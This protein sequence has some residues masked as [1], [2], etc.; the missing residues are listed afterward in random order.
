MLPLVWWHKKFYLLKPYQTEINECQKRYKLL[1]KWFRVVLTFIFIFK[2]ISAPNDARVH[3]DSTKNTEDAYN[4]TKKLR[5][6]FE[7]SYEKSSIFSF[8]CYWLDTSFKIFT[9][10]VE[11]SSIYKYHLKIV[12][13]NANFNSELFLIAITQ[14]QSVLNWKFCPFSEIRNS[15]RLKRF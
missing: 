13:S 1:L 12:V 6:I 15:C 5:K 11:T 9:F 14:I 7:I 8:K 2:G 10:M 3:F 4:E